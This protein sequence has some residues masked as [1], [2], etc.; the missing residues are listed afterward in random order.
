[1]SGFHNW[2]SIEQAW[3]ATE[4]CSVASINDTILATPKGESSWTLIKREARVR[5]IIFD[6]APPQQRII[7]KI[8]RVPAHLGWRTLGMVSRANRE[9]TALMEAHRKGLPVARPHSWQELRVFGC[10]RFSSVSLELVTGINLKDLLSR[11]LTPDDQR[12]QLAWEKRHLLRKLHKSGLQWGTAF[13]RN[14]T[15]QN[16]KHPVA[17]KP[18]LRVIDTPY[19]IWYDADISGEST[20]LSDLRN[21]IQVKHNGVGFTDLER[22]QLILGYCGD[23]MHN[24]SNLISQLQP[25]P[26]NVAKLERWRR[27]CTNVLVHSLRSQRPGGRYDEATGAYVRSSEVADDHI[28]R[29]IDCPE[30]DAPKGRTNFI[31]G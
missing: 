30:S 2:S 23:D 29:D 8:Y 25:R 18:L 5:L 28:E 12:L 1:M 20:T 9:F 26:R 24:H 4:H 14:I 13:S 3:A 31:S 15:M 21:V 19:A 22:T 17:D 6:P 16:S 27:R 11:K 7:C 10:V